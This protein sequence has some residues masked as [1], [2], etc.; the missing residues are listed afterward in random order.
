MSHHNISSK[1]GINGWYQKNINQ[2]TKARPTYMNTFDRNCSSACCRLP[3][4]AKLKIS[5]IY[6]YHSPWKFDAWIYHGVEYLRGVGRRSA[7]TPTLKKEAKNEMGKTPIPSENCTKKCMEELKTMRCKW[8]IKPALPLSLPQWKPPGKPLNYFYNDRLAISF[9]PE[10]VP[11]AEHAA[12]V[13]PLCVGQYC[14]FLL[15]H[16]GEWPFRYW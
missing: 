5:V 2:K 6:S 15:S 10:M 14:R 12:L 16:K 8:V 3:F 7:P 4:A 1:G 13:E 11:R 9:R